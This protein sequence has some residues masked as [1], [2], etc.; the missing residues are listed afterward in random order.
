M[1][2]E[3]GD[4]KKN[5]YISDDE[6]AHWK[7]AGSDAIRRRYSVLHD[8]AH[9]VEK[10]DRESVENFLRTTSSQYPEI[11]LSSHH[12]KLSSG[13]L[14]K[15]KKRLAMMGD[16]QQTSFHL[17]LL[18]NTPVPPSPPAA[19][20]FLFA[21]FGP[22]ACVETML[23]D[24]AELFAADCV[25]RGH[26]RAQLLYWSRTLRSILPLVIAKLRTWGIIAA[27]IGYGRSKIGW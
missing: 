18:S 15:L 11:F 3:P 14:R 21:I 9:V 27:V 19:A 2:D 24:L 1:T 25:K 6:T 26:R 23:G 17:E 12:T 16:R 20:E 7:S 5:P 4:R 22:K 8:C 10:E 13:Q